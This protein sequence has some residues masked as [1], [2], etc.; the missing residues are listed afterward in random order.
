MRNSIQGY[1][2]VLCTVMSTEYKMPYFIL[3][4]HLVFHFTLHCT[5]GGTAAEYRIHARASSGE[6][7]TDSPP[8]EFHSLTVD[9]RYSLRGKR[10]AVVP[11]GVPFLLPIYKYMDG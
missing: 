5:L 6:K 11:C 4:F 7:L 10:W 9:H 1:I 3:L 8:T 2:S